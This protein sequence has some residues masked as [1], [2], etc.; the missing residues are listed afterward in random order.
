VPLHHEVGVT[1]EGEPGSRDG[2]ADG[3]SNT[4]RRVLAAFNGSSSDHPASVRLLSEQLAADGKG[5]ALK[6]RTIQKPSTSSKRGE[7]DERTRRPDRVLHGEVDHVALGRQRGQ[8][9]DQP[10]GAVRAGPPER[11]LPMCYSGVPRGKTPS[12]RR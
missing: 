8:E 5:Y 11:V 3:L 12:A 4:Q 2:S 7:F 10:D 1:D 6:P 9:L